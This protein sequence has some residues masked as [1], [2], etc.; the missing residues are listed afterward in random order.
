MATE[1]S[2]RERIITEAIRLFGEH[3]F[4]R[5]TVGEIEQAAG[6][7]PRSGGLYKHFRSKEEVLEAAIDRHVREI[8]AVRSVLDFRPLGDVR[9][10]LTLIARWGLAE[11]AAEQPVMRI[12]MK[13]GDEF[14]E[15]V[16]IVKERIV[17]RGTEMAVAV[18]ERLLGEA[19]LAV[20]NAAAIATI[21]LGSLV[22]YR[23]QESMFGTPPGGLGED[24]FIE[25]WV[26]VWTTFARNA[27]AV[28]ETAAAAATT[29]VIAND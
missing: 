24:E 21:S 13:D 2:T 9:A 20:S 28:D 10:E 27:S 26:Q 1:P 15:L 6:L 3:G 29:G 8:D 17:E 16:Q 5:T 22:N 7:V 19:G 12:V 25:A 14:P 4:R 18:M 23:I 11:L